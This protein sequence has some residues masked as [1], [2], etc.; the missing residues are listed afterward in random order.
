MTMHAHLHY[1]VGS[2]I[3]P[4]GS[5]KQR[6]VHLCRPMV[7]AK[8]TPVSHSIGGVL[9]HVSFL[10]D[11]GAGWTLRCEDRSCDRASDPAAPE[12]I[13]WQTTVMSP[14]VRILSPDS[15]LAMLIFGTRDDLMHP[16]RISMVGFEIGHSR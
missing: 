8:G 14:C 5:Y 12:S 9:C 4:C 3:V 2:G 11:K 1:I 16:N 15:G 13:C 10:L 7:S 6:S